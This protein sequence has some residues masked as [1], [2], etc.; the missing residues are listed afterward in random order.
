MGQLGGVTIVNLRESIGRQGLNSQDQ[1]VFI[2]GHQVRT[3][4]SE[5]T[6]N[7]TKVR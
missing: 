2:E 1:T 5:K 4:L 7:L 3:T 6:T